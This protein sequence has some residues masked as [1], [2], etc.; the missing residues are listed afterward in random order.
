MLA[1][2]GEQLRLDKLGKPNIKGLVHRQQFRTFTSVLSR[3][4]PTVMTIVSTQVTFVAKLTLCTGVFVVALDLA[5]PAWQTT[6]S[7]A[8]SRLVW[9]SSLRVPGLHWCAR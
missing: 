4:S 5:L 7:F 9:S 6:E 3:I 8:R 2:R 1:G